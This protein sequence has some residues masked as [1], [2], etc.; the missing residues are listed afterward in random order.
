MYNYLDHLLEPGAE[1]TSKKDKSFLEGPSKVCKLKK[2][3]ATSK[4]G[5]NNTEKAYDDLVL[6]INKTSDDVFY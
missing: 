5:I 2:A 3:F 6:S 4:G 1:Q